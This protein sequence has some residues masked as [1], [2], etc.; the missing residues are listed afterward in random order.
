[1]KRF[2]L[3]A[4]LA[5]LPAVYATA[6]L[7]Q[8]AEPYPNTTTA[9]TVS[10]ADVIA[11]VRAAQAAGDLH[12]GEAQVVRDVPGDATKSRAEVIAELR[13]AR[14]AGDVSYG[15]AQLP[16]VATTARA[17]VPAAIAG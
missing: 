11:E 9:S 10:R 1:M 6:A 3:S 13:A 15:E 7:A 14:A 2:I 17:R 8:E 4:A 16:S 5:A 12:W